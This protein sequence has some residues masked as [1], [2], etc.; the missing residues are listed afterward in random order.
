ML[1]R[2]QSGVLRTTYHK[3]AFLKSPFDVV[4]YLHLLDRLRPRTVIEIGSKH[5]ASALWFADV[6]S[7]L[8]VDGR[9]ISVD[10]EPPVDLADSRILFLRGNAA[11][12]EK[13]LSDEML[14]ALPRP[15][16]VTEDSAHTFSV[17]LAALEFFDKHLKPGDYI[18]IED[19]IVNDLPGETYKSFRDGPNRAV[20]T[21]LSERD[22]YMIDA[23]LCDHFGYNVTYNP[24]GWLRRK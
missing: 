15:W 12:L 4:L 17:C 20:A 24:N 19:G 13:V 8:G 21:F 14:A 9:V 16:L 11:S 3:R 1:A 18:V 23:E 22:D 10:L 2:I 7:A 6:L 5:G